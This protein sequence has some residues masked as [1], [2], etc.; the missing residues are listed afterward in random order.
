M[1][2]GLTGKARAGKD[3][4]ARI[5]F[6][7]H[8][9]TRLAIADPLK[10]TV[11]A[12]YGLDPDEFHD[13]TLKGQVEPAWGLTRRAMMQS[14][15]EMVKKELGEDFWMRHWFRRYAQLG[16][17]H[18]VVVTDVRFNHEAEKLI[19]LGGVI[20]EIVRED[21]GLVGEEGSHVSEQGLR[22]DL[23]SHRLFNDGPIG[24]LT[25]EIAGLV[26]VM[27]GR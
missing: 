21:A 8:G 11:A 24:D 23:I 9:F 4:V 26:R 25:Y 1:L 10:E 12:L 3:T 19:M 5:L 7:E 17:K 16:D 20:V 13:D 15:G 6:M 27:R 18:S 22:S 2:I 14:V